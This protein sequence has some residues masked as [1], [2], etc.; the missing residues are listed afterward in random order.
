[1]ITIL[2]NFNDDQRNFEYKCLCST[3]NIIRAYDH[4]ID[5]YQDSINLD[6]TE[7]N[8]KHIPHTP[9][10]HLYGL[11]SINLRS[12][13]LVPVS[14]GTH[15]VFGGC[16]Q[17]WGHG[18]ERKKDLWSYIVN[19]NFKDSAG[20]YN[21]G[22]GGWNTSQIVADAI[23]YCNGFGMPKYMFLLFPEI[24]REVVT[25]LSKT[26]KETKLS[27]SESRYLNLLQTQSTFLSLMAIENFCAVNNITLRYSTWHPGTTYQY[28]KWKLK[29]FLPLFDINNPDKFFF[30]KLQNDGHWA[31][32][33]NKKFA[34]MVL[35]SL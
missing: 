11:N 6:Y 3:F 25:F 24:D 20:Y 16:S 9:I 8:I 21:L 32:T 28:S 29:N 26:T 19:Q 35:E 10:N 27:K 18:I 33:H 23:A 17:T 22:R 2:K 4:N 34:E 5:C 30:S 31:V 1:M 13:E 15:I 14:S 12:D 7:C